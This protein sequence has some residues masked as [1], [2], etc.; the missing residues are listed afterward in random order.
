MA[1]GKKTATGR[2]LHDPLQDR[3][4]PIYPLDLS[5][6]STIDDLVR[7]MG[8]TAFTARQ[9]GDAADVLEA[10]VRDPDCFVVLTLSGAMTVAKMGLVICDLIDA[11]AVQAIVSTGALMAHGLVKAPAARLF[12]SIPAWT[13]G[14]CFW[15]GTI[16]STIRSSQKSISTTSKPSPTASSHP[17]IPAS[18]CVAG[19]CIS[20]SATIWS[21]TSA[22]GAF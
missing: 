4:Q 8:Q 12:A 18:R 16:A 7:A 1:K 15:P 21:G 14:S 13:T 20:A 10:M 9:V 19:S 17:G 11:G 22:G 3:L 6:I 5:R 2:V